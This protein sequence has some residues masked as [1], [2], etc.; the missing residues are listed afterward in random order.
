MEDILEQY[1][2]SSYPLPDRLLAWLLF[3]AGL[4]SFGRDGRPVTLPLPSYGPDE[5]LVR[6]DAVGL[7][8]SD[9][10][11]ITQ[12]NTHPRIQGRDL[13]VDPVIPGHEVSLTVVGVGENL[14]GSFKVGDRFIVQA[15]IYYKGVNLAYGYALRGGLA[16]YG[17]VGEKILHGDEGCYLLP[18]HSHIGYA[19]AALTEPW[20]CVEASYSVSLRSGLKA[21]GL[22]WILGGGNQAGSQMVKESPM[23]RGAPRRMKIVLFSREDLPEG[24]W[25]KKIVLT[26]VGA[27]VANFW[28]RHIQSPQGWETQIIETGGLERNQFEKIFVQETEGRGFDDIILLDPHDLQIVE[29]AARSLARHGILNL[30]LSKP[31]H[32]KVGIDVGRVHYDGIIY[33]GSVGPDIL[34]CYKEEQTSELKGKGTVWFVGAGGPM[35]QIQIQRA[36]QLEKSPRKIVATNFRSPRLKSLEGRF[37]KMARE[38]GVEIVFLTQQDMGEEQFYQRMEEEAEGRGF[39]DIVILCS[40]P[41]VMERT[42][43]YLAKGGTMNIFAGVPKGTLAYIDAD[44]LCSRRIKFVGS[45]GSLITHLEGVLR[46][47]EKGTISP[48]SS[49]AAIAGMDSVIDGLKAVKEGRFP[50]KVVVFPQIKEL[51][52]TP[53]PELK[54]KLPR[55]YEKLEEGQMWSREAEEELLRQKLRR[56]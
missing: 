45:S 18:I 32:G 38:R 3:G 9:I 50:G 8:Y 19:E 2:A 37:K 35:G 27:P 22:T 21:G 36:L 30:I 39:D 43:S 17:V 13:A 29:E 53:L 56:L 54:E 49:V 5:L 44:L 20:A 12:G 11:L 42:T 14:R 40:V 25:P 24:S 41:Q 46:K 34:A 15:D 48:N 4:D 7:C 16:Q 26:N 47:T 52:L 1:Q 31:R 51:E 55:V 33:R 6:S 28:K 23:R 10:K